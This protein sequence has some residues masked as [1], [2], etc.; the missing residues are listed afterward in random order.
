[1]GLLLREGGKT[2]VESA[3]VGVGGIS[4]HSFGGEEWELFDLLI[5]HPAIPMFFKIIIT[6][7]ML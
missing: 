7:L 3:G 5:P 4:G 1:M 2:G 6:K